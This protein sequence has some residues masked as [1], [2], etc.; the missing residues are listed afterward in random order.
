MSPMIDGPHILHF[1]QLLG[2]ATYI[3]KSV[4]SGRDKSLLILGGI[5]LLL[6]RLPKLPG[7]FEYYWLGNLDNLDS[8]V[9]RHSLNQTVNLN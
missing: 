5:T 3:N 9:K 7:P 6:I 2:L 8:T 1:D 4:I